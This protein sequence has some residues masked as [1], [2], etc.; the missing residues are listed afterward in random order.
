MNDIIKQAEDIRNIQAETSVL[1][2]EI[3]L[4]N[5]NDSLVFPVLVRLN[6][7]FDSK[8]SAL[9]L[10]LALKNFQQGDDD[11]ALSL[12]SKA[13]QLAPN[14]PDIL[15]TSAFLHAAVGDEM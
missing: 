8:D 1:K 10:S 2:L 11:Q 4:S 15:R 12:V 3:M 13:L 6:E 5:A 7:I 9:L 14:D